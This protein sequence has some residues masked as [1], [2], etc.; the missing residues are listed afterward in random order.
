MKEI[1]PPIHLKSMSR[2]SFL[3]YS[4]ELLHDRRKLYDLLQ[5][6]HHYFLALESTPP[7]TNALQKLTLESEC[8]LLKTK[9]KQKKQDTRDK[10]ELKIILGQLFKVFCSTFVS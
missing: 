10:R 6:H 8:I 9:K 2:L 7:L 3:L 1:V 5:E 4:I